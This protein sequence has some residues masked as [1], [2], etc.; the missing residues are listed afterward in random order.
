MRSISEL[1]LVRGFE[2]N[3][4]YQAIKKFVCAVDGQTSINVNTAPAEVL[5]SIA[6]NINTK[7]IIDKRDDVEGFKDINDFITSNSLTKVV[8]VTTGLSTSSDYFLLESEYVI[9]Q[10]RTVMYSIINRDNTGKITVTG[11][12]QGAY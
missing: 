2:N 5:S 8:T 10:S 3:D 7:D 12:S 1:R 6:N 11:R 4:T 9:G